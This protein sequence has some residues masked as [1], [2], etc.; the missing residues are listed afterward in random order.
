MKMLMII[1]F[2]ET[3]NNESPTATAMETEET[4]EREEQQLLSAN[5]A[6]FA[7]SDIS[8][9][10]K[11][12]LA[13][14][15]EESISNIRAIFA[16]RIATYDTIRSFNKRKEEALD[17]YGGADRMSGRYG[18]FLSDGDGRMGMVNLIV[19][20]GKKTSKTYSFDPESML[21]ALCKDRDHKVM[22]SG[23]GG[24]SR[25]EERIVVFAGDQALPPGWRS[26]DRTCPATIRI[27]YGSLRDIAEE[28]A[29]VSRGWR[30]PPGSIIFLSSATQL[31]GAGLGHYMA[32]F[33]S[34]AS[35]LDGH[36][37][38]DVIVLPGVPFLVDGTDAPMLI[39]ALSDMATWV[40]EQAGYIETVGPAFS[41]M[42]ELLFNNGGG[43]QQPQYP[44]RYWLTD[45]AVPSDSAKQ[46][47]WSSSGEVGLPS[48]VAAM[49]EKEEQEL[50]SCILSGLKENQNLDICLPGASC[51][52][53]AKVTSPV[54]ILVV[55]A[56][57][58]ARLAT[59]L[60]GLGITIGRVTTTNWKPSKES[61]EILAAH[62]K[63]SVEGEKPAAVVFNMHDN[64]LY[65]GRSID[66]TT[67][68]AFKDKKGHFHVEGE[69]VLA[70]KDVQLNLYRLMKPILEAAG[71]KPFI[72]ITPMRRYAINPCCANQDHVTNISSESYE[73][74]MVN[75][76]EEVRTNMRSWLFSDNI[77]RA[78]VLDPAQLMNKMGS[79]I[80]WGDDPVHPLPVVY[81]EL[82]KLV[83]SSKD[84]LMDK[85]ETA[86]SKP[87]RPPGGSRDWR[88][89][90]GGRWG[91]GARGQAGYGYH[92]RTSY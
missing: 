87:S 73:E 50:L 64:L 91:R 29:A 49:S 35:W 5:T 58:S 16:D 38:G 40:S 2:L 10:A 18:D 22:S 34:L 69:L 48:K 92:G 19:N 45:N 88:D 20:F 80:C 61:V 67:K 23:Y 36:F 55:G 70:P 86:C 26:S 21:C 89:R 60:E 74:K 84:K 37:C 31:L 28:V 66:G 59:A 78:V 39:R 62:V 3:N 54:H 85:I 47:P 41:K 25:S 76:L 32:E 57:N 83:L 90:R 63:S 75:D 44:A 81:E 42:K 7:D 71:Q 14:K 72:I 53:G 77:R 46:S 79:R 43:T 65:M 6:T 68:Q 56:S 9:R 17:L 30:I 13:K 12:Y 82:A 33:C 52:T 15:K 8:D 4:G 1:L 27:E 11:A 24:G 51:R